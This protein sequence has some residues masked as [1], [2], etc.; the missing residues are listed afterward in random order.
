MKQ[1][2]EFYKEIY[3]CGT[4]LGD[5]YDFEHYWEESL[6]KEVDQLDYNILINLI[7]DRLISLHNERNEELDLFNRNKNQELRTMHAAVNMRIQMEI[8]FLH[9]IRGIL[10]N[11]NA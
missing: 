7:D 6:E 5:E 4:R 8:K 1:T 10:E 2:K 3:D 9:K 11:G